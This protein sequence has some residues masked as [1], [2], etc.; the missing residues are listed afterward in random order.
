MIVAMTPP[1]IAEALKPLPGWA[2]Q[3]GCIL[4]EFRFHSYMDGIRFVEAVAVE[5]EA[6]DHHPDLLVKFASVTVFLAT[7]SANGLTYKDF[8]LA[9]RVEKAYLPLNPA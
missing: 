9:A 2:Y 4:K 7:H 1:E 5:A 3:E 6:V 8:D